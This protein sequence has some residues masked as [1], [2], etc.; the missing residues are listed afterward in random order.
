MKQRSYDTYN[1]YGEIREMPTFENMESFG[2]TLLQTPLEALNIV[3][4]NTDMD[5]MKDITDINAEQVISDIV[6]KNGLSKIMNSVEETQ[7]YQKI[8]YNFEY[9]PDVL[10]TYGP[11]FNRE[12]LHK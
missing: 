2:Y 12:H 1:K 7:Q 4:P 6:G 11:I 5:K 10:K 3:Y 8:R 9:K